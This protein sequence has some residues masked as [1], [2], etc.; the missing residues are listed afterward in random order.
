[1]KRATKG[2]KAESRRKHKE[3]INGSLREGKG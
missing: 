2:R 1:L 3:K